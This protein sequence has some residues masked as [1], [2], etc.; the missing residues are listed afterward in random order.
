MIGL[1][2]GIL[3][4]AMPASAS[5]ILG[6]AASFAILGAAAVTNTGVTTVNGDIGVSPG[7]AL[8]GLGTVSDTGTIHQG[9]TVASQAQQDSSAAFTALAG[10]PAVSLLTGEDLGSV[11][12]LAPGVYRFASSAQL[13]GALTLN[14]AAGPGSAYVFQIGS[15]L[16]TATGSSIVVQNG[17]ANSEIYWDVGSSATLGIGSTFVGNIIAG[18]SIGLNNSASIVCGR[19]IALQG[20]VTLQGNTIDDNCGA[21]DFGSDGYSGSAVATVAEP[22]SGFL[23]IGGLVG[24]MALRRARRGPALA[25]LHPG[26]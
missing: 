4:V 25:A 26:A 21:G 23:L 20:A 22:A 3:G 15:E 8:S 9:D 5:V 18:Q 7:S 1:V 10:L 2:A 11:G 14:F 19:A 16:T 17:T 24:L 13:T 12:V 6:S